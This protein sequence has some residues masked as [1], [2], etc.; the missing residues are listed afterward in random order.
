MFAVVTP[1]E[2]SVIDASSPVPVEILISRAGWAV[3]RAARKM[4]GGTYGR[5]VTVLAGP[6]NN[7]ADGMVAAGILRRWGVRTRIIRVDRNSPP[8]GVVADCDLV[9]DAAFGTGFRGT[10]VAPE[11]GSIPVLAVDIASGVDGLTGE[12]APESVPFVCAHTVTFA[13]FKPGLLQGQGPGF[14]GVIEVAD[15]GLGT[16]SSVHLLDEATAR[17]R[18]SARPRSA[19]KWHA[20]VLVIGGSVGMN[21]APSLA[22]R[23]AMRAGAGMVRLAIPGD[24]HP[25]AGSQGSEIVGVPMAGSAWVD[26][27]ISALERCGALIVGPGLRR[28]VDTVACVSAL[29]ETAASVPMV[30]DADGL[31]AVAGKRFPDR[32]PACGVVLTP[33]DGEYRMITGRAVGE[34][35]IAAARLLAEDT[36]AV[37]LL[38]GPTTVVAGPTGRVEL[39]ANGDSRLATAGSGDVLSGIIGALMAQGLPSFEAAS[40]AAFIHGGAAQLGSRHGFIASDIIGHLPAWFDNSVS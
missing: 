34:D 4:L 28:H 39:V 27:A 20:A 2:M 10:F 16:P 29:I 19:H 33:H 1:E 5:H 26:T 14:C 3:A 32:P 31:M 12:V 36:N 22:S 35:R 8:P 38:K 15:I 37:V 21:G 9:I 30:I 6:G 23:A 13:A 17:R 11:V 24:A 25:N 40:T 7:G 18:I